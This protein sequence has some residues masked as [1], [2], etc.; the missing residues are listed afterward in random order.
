MIKFDSFIAKTT[1]EDLRRIEKDRIEINAAYDNVIFVF[2]LR[3]INGGKAFSN[4]PKYF[5]ILK[6]K[7]MIFIYLNIKKGYSADTIESDKNAN[8]NNNNNG[9]VKSNDSFIGSDLQD[10]IDRYGFIQ[11]ALS[12]TI[13]NTSDK[14]NS[15]FCI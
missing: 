8:N 12:K 1:E 10:R 5:Q 14:I 2:L 11:Y 4:Y 15:I 6:T 7:L 13:L 3:L 9:T